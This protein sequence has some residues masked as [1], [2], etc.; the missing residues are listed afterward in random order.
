MAESVRT[1]S[2]NRTQRNDT[3][4]RA[5]ARHIIASLIDT[6]DAA[7]STDREALELAVM[8]LAAGG[9]LL[10]EDVPGI[11]KTTLARALAAA[12][13]G[14]VSRI[15][16]TPDMLPSDI[17]GVSVFNQREQQFTFYKGPIFAQIALADEINRANPKTQAALLEAMEEKRVTVDGTTYDLP[18][19]FTVIATQNPIEM[20]G[21]YPLP[22]AQLDRFMCRISLGYP[23]PQAEA[24]MLMAPSGRDPLAG[25]K[26]L[27]TT[28]DILA[29][30]DTAA[31]VH[32][33]PAIASYAVAL[34]AAT[35]ES[36]LT[37]LGASPRAGLALLA[38]SRVR[39]LVHGQDAVYPGDV[40]AMAPAVLAHRI[41]FSD[42]TVGAGALARQQELL[43]RILRDV[44]AP[45][46]A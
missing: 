37:R 28:R 1:G 27:C 2:A 9:H 20:E 34:L 38:M 4:R 7:L 36:P 11:G 14:D 21:T 29:I 31:H 25:M 17:T 15:Q 10:L 19:P 45:R 8:T 41:V 6:L 13:Q 33:A 24:R 18:R 39:A 26:P 35:R 40:R 42:A 44:P 16:F 3:Q 12:I 23:H 46:R 5:A 43:E 22:E 30:T 32:V